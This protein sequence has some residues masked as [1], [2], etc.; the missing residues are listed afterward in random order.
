LK[1]L[2]KIGSAEAIEAI[3]MTLKDLKKDHGWDVRTCR[4]AIEVLRTIGSDDA[5][6]A[7]IEALKFPYDYVRTCAAAALGSIGSNQAVEP[8]IKALKD[9]DSQV[10]CNAALALGSIGS[11]QAVE[12]LIMALNDERSEVRSDA[13]DSLRKISKQE[14]IS[15]KKYKIPREIRHELHSLNKSMGHLARDL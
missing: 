5:F 13:L 9:Q 8:L 2:G 15:M 3:I 6:N 4:G 10:R 7:I 12:P 14:G 11:N 1:A